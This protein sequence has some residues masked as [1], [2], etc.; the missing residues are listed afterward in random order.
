MSNRPVNPDLPPPH[1]LVLELSG[2]EGGCPMGCRHCLHRQMA[3]SPSPLLDAGEVQRLLVQGRDMGI[4]QLNVS[5]HDDDVSLPPHGLHPLL[6]LA[7]GLGYRVK[8]VTN[9]ADPEGVRLM[10]PYWALFGDRFGLEIP[11]CLTRSL[12]TVR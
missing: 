5:L 11:R 6:V 7:H 4:A 1:N 9:G 12:R 8:T 3:P 2:R 10:L